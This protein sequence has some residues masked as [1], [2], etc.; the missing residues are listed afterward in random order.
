[1]AT[2]TPG[3]G[4]T[5]KSVT[6]EGQAIEAL[7][8]L[9]DR[10]NTTT[11]NPNGED[12][13]DGNFDTDLRTFSGQFRIPASQSIN[14]SG[15]LV[16]Q[17]V[18][19][20]NGGAFTPGSDGTFKSTAIEAFVLEVLMYLQVLESTPAK[21]PN[22]RNYVTGTFNA[23]TGIY[24]GSFSLPIAFALAEDGSVKIQAVEYLLT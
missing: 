18:P 21:N 7:I 1:M 12:R 15:Q 3:T 13:L 14:G 19:Y 22:N 11:A 17:A 6:A 5:F 2:I 4:G 24:T 23:D 10:E 9:Q 16:I 8:Y 20:L